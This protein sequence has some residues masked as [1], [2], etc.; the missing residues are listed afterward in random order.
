MLRDSN[1]TNYTRELQTFRFRF[2]I[3]ENRKRDCGKIAFSNFIFTRQ[4][5][6]ARLTIF[7]SS[8]L[9]RK[10]SK[11]Y[12]AIATTT[13]HSSTQESSRALRPLTAPKSIPAHLFPP[14]RA[15]EAHTLHSRRDGG[16]SGPRAAREEF[17]ARA[18]YATE[19]GP[20]KRRLRVSRNFFSASL[21]P[22]RLNGIYP[23]HGSP[24]SARH[25]GRPDGDRYYYFC[26]R[27]SLSDGAIVRST[28]AIMCVRGGDGGIVVVASLACGIW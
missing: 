8:N 18:T 25:E 15:A 23:W 2:N 27:D 6:R 22:L 21:P 16:K 13:T 14:S 28:R 12:E 17:A 20:I 10:N 3:H 26:V 4:K 9:L 1:K 24:S 11:H 5:S 7:P 19:I